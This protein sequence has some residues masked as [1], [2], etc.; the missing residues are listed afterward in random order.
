MKDAYDKTLWVFEHGY[1]G[2][3]PF[4][5][6]E[7]ETRD[8]P[9]SASCQVIDNW[10]RHSDRCPSLDRYDEALKEAKKGVSIDEVLSEEYERF[11]PLIAEIVRENKIDAAFEIMSRFEQAR[12]E[13]AEAAL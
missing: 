4:L 13:Y 5:R 7:K 8:C 3:C 11:L 9:G 2:D 10:N 12:T 6:R 1:C